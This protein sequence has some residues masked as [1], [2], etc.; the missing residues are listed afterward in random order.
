LLATAHRLLIALFETVEVMQRNRRGFPGLAGTSRRDRVPRSE[1]HHHRG[2]SRSSRTGL[3]EDP[4]GSLVCDRHAEGTT[5]SIDH[6]WG[7]NT[8]EHML[9]SSRER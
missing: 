7:R 9:S 3:G 5:P 6:G 8:V 1:S 2:H 4:P